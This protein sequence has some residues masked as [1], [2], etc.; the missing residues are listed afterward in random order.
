MKLQLREMATNDMIEFS[1]LPAIIGRDSTADIQLD[2]PA[3]PP[4]QCVIG[5]GADDGVVVWNLREDFPL[6]VNG[7]RIMEAQ[8]LLG[9]SDHR[10]D[11]IRVLL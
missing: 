11:S 9:E 10:Q 6:Y 1:E 7:R 4:Y 8:L 5:R 2:D 3:L